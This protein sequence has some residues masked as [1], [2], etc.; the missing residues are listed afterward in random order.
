MDNLRGILEQSADM[1]ALKVKLTSYLYLDF[2]IYCDE[3]DSNRK[4]W[5]S[6]MDLHLTINAQVILVS[7][8]IS[9]YG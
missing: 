3:I 1:S 7:Q 2:N 8:P 9:V 5:T 6:C 4:W